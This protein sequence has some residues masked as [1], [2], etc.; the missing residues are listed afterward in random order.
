MTVQAQG[1]GA[2]DEGEPDQVDVRGDRDS[3]VLGDA[4]VDL[5]ATSGENGPR[6]SVLEVVGAPPCCRMPGL[7]GKRNWAVVRLDMGLASH[8]GST[9]DV[10]F[11]TGLEG[12][13]CLR[14]QRGA[15]PRRQPAR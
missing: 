4:A 14:R 7:G 10:D 12:R 3:A 9:D 15:T 6:S 2:A 8:T 1:G 5:E 13:G 11:A